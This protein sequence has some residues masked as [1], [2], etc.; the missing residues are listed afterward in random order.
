MERI[1]ESL[2]D[3]EKEAL[4]RSRAVPMPRQVDR[5]W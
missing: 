4:E 1:L 2:K 5:D 3:E